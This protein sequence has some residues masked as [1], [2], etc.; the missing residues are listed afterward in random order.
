MEITHEMALKLARLIMPH[1][2]NFY[3]QKNKNSWTLSYTNDYPLQHGKGRDIEIHNEVIQFILFELPELFYEKLNNKIKEVS[4]KG[5][6]EV[7]HSAYW[8]KCGLEDSKSILLKILLPHEP[9]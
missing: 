4:E 9:T 6:G 7:P 5:D 8:Q 2:D 1:G 3:A